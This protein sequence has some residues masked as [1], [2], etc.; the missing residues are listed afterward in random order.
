MGNSSTSKV[1]GLLKVI[2]KMI[3]G[4]KLSLNNILHVLNIHK[5]L[6]SGS[7]L[8]KNGFK[9]IFVSDKFVLTKN[10]VYANAM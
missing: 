9:L 5:N 7:F 8:S 2:L 10:N 3:S 6:V 4:K 1:E